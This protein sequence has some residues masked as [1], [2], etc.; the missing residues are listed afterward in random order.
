MLKSTIGLSHYSYLGFL[1]TSTR[2]TRQD[3]FS[4]NMLFLKNIVHLLQ[5]SM[6]FLLFCLGNTV[7][8]TWKTH[9]HHH[10]HHHHHYYYYYCGLLYIRKQNIFDQRATQSYQWK[11]ECT[12]VLN[13]AVLRKAHELLTSIYAKIN[14]ENRIW[15]HRRTIYKL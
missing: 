4:S 7:H 14:T 1:S 5:R 2:R 11:G 6:T 3:S 12:S 8:K 10:H 15:G 9:H 13:G